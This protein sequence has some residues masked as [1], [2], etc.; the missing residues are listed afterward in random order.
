MIG[1]FLIRWRW[2]LAIAAM[3]VAGLAYAFWPQPVAVDLG[4]VSRGPM[5]VGITDDGVTR[6]EEYYV[7]AA[8]VTGYLSRIELEPGDRVARGSLLATMSGRPATPLDPRGA[9]ALRAALAS[10]RA[11]EA[12]AS[13]ALSQAARDLLRAEELARRGF[14]PKAQ[15]E[16]ARTRVTLG[17]AAV[18]Q[19]R[20]EAAR[21]AAELAPA[22]GQPA[23]GTV[24]VRAPVG[25]TVLSVITESEGSLAE[26]TPLVTIGDPRRIEVVVDLLSREAVRVKPGDR[27]RIEQW[28]GPQ[29]LTV[30]VQRVEPFGRLKVSALGIEEQRVNVIIGFDPASAAEGARLGHGYQIDATILVWSR[31]DALRVPIGALFRG[32]DGSWQVFV[33]SGRSA[34]ARSLRIGRINDQWGE[35]LSGLGQGDQVVLNPSPSL[36]DGKRVTPRQ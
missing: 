17:Q 28:G 8:P 27:V 30:R 16:S 1:R 21:V 10:A 33:V 23:P 20:A 18:R 5:E 12:S 2:A 6:A 15:L 35:V 36:S 29:P 34:R 19:A 11:A 3:L 31:P 14:L 9:E 7:V 24:P 13:A 32:D 22:R 26:G 4:R 25:G